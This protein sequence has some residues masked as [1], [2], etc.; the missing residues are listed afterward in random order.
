[1]TDSYSLDDYVADLREIVAVSSDEPLNDIGDGNTEID[2][3]LNGDL[4]AELRAERAGP[5]DGRV[6]T[7]SVECTDA[8]GNTSLPATATVSVAHDRGS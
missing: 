8:S 6:Y 7:L 3:Q 5:R 1:M 2:W 4:T